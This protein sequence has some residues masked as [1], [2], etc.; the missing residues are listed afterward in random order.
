MSGLDEQGQLVVLPVDRSRERLSV[1]F[2]FMQIAEFAQG[3]P[4]TGIGPQQGALQEHP[5]DVAGVAQ[6]HVHL[7]MAHDG[8]AVGRGEHFLGQTQAVEE[9]ERLRTLWQHAA[10]QPVGRADH[11]TAADVAQRGHSLHRQ[12]EEQ[13]ETDAE[14]DAGQ[15][16]KPLATATARADHYRRQPP[17]GQRFRQGAVRGYGQPLPLTQ[18]GERHRRER[19][20]EQQRPTQA[21][22]RVAA[23]QQPVCGIAQEPHGVDEDE[24]DQ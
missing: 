10:G 4:H 24:G 6:A 7:L 8:L 17:C 11:G 1:G 15:P 18:Q 22:K 16:V 3:E 19:Q 14:I 2:E 21:K 9:G 20:A 23:G 12:P 5:D 13:Q